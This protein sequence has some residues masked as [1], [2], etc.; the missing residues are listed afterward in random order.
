MMLRIALGHVV[1]VFC[2]GCSANDVED[3]GEHLWNCNSVD[4]TGVG[5]NLGGY[6]N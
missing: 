4:E 6:T 2:V 1:I 3:V 5:G